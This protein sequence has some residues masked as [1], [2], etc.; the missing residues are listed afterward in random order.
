MRIETRLTALNHTATRVPTNTDKAILICCTVTVIH[1]RDVTYLG[2][3]PLRPTF[4]RLG[5]VLLKSHFA[6]LFF[7]SGQSYL[8][9]ALLGQP[10]FRPAYPQYSPCLCEGVAGLRLATPFT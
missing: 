5:P 6:N 3:V 2:Q 7:Y 4:F 10:L 1:M 8:G 9:K